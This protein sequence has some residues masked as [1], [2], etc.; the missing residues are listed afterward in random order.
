ML[1]KQRNVSLSSNSVS[2]RCIPFLVTFVNR[3][4]G[5]L[6]FN[7]VAFLLPALYSTLSKLWVANIDSSLV[8]TTDVY[9]YISVIANVLNDGLPRTAWLIIGDRSTRSIE[10]RISLSHTLIIFQAVLGA[11]MSV[12]FGVAAH[13]FASSFVPPNVRAASL[14]YVRLS[15]PV[16]LTSAIQVSVSSCT[17]AL[18]QPDIPLVISSTSVIVNII[19]DLLLI[20][21]FPRQI[22]TNHQYTGNQPVGL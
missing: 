13:S 16:A 3:Y 18:D 11:I 4:I 1:S 8:V 21:K 17:R 20:S 15:A 6:A 22:S 19:L 5:S 9:T 2:F 7:L 14:T 12:I 10:S